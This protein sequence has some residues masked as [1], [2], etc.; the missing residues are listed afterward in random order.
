LAPQRDPRR[1]QC[2]NATYLVTNSPVRRRA[3]H[4]AARSR[5]K[6]AR[7]DGG[8]HRGDREAALE[9]AGERHVQS[10]VA[11]RKSRTQNATD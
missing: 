7:V 8:E 2:E 4:L 10:H 9:A 5:I 1:A 3:D 11:H 6:L